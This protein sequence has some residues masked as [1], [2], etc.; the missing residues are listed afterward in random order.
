MDGI[1]NRRVKKSLTEWSCITPKPRLQL[2]GRDSNKLKFS[3]IGDI[4]YIT[5]PQSEDEIL[6]VERSNETV[7]KNNIDY[8]SY[9]AEKNP[10]FGRLLRNI[11]KTY[12]PQKIIIDDFV[13]V[14]LEEIQFKKKMIDMLPSMKSTLTTIGFSATSIFNGLTPGKI[15]IKDYMEILKK[16]KDSGRISVELVDNNIYMWKIKMKSFEN[17]E[18]SESLKIVN[19]EYGYDDIELEITFHDTMYP[20]Y[21]PFIRIVRPRI[22]KIMHQLSNLQMTKFEYWTPGRSMN[23]VIDTLYNIINKHATI[24][25]NNKVNDAQIYKNGAYLPLEESFLK[26]ATFCDDITYENEGMKLDDTQ[27]ECIYQKNS[28]KETTKDTTKKKTGGSVMND[29]GLGYVFS[30]K[31]WDHKEYI[32]LHKEKDLQLQQIIEKII[33]EI[34]NTSED[35]LHNLYSVIKSSFIMKLMNTYLHGTTILNMFEHRSIYMALFKLLQQFAN[36]NAIFLFD[37]KIIN[38]LIELDEDVNDY[39]KLSESEKEETD[40]DTK[41]TNAIRV[42]NE[43]VIPLYEKHTENMKKYEQSKKEKI[44]EL[45]KIDPNNIYVKEMKS[46]CC[47]MV[48]LTGKKQF[49]YKVKGTLNRK[50]I[51]RLGTEIA[52]FKKC[53]PIH[54]SSS[55]FVRVDENDIR[56]MRVAITGPEDTAYDS[57]IFVFDLYI[58]D[59]YPKTPP[60]MNIVNQ[61]RFRFNPNLYADGKVCLSLLGTWGTNQWDVTST[62]QQLFVSIQGQIMVDTPMYNEPSYEKHYG[63]SSGDDMNKK[64][65]NHVRYYNMKYTMCEMLKSQENYPEFSS[66]V[67]KHFT[68]KRDHILKTCKQWVDESFDSNGTIQHNSSVTIEMYKTQYK[69]LEELL[70]KLATENEQKEMIDNVDKKLTEIEKRL[71]KIEDEI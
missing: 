24:D 42:L 5:Y 15:L 59:T 66:V 23:I 32:K 10:T 1:T 41:L 70:N 36:E 6:F 26:L 47:D 58:V 30:G 11:E 51:R 34:D 2:I 35:D 62:L 65:N 19:K 37:D 16:Y 49:K 54:S 57:G 20:T 50:A 39:M 12:H 4:L 68:L 33:L 7:A 27:Y 29:K 53:L 61:G 43:M 44:E 17:K 64:Y 63:T 13:N 22:N 18:L 55:V 67:K 71:A 60:Q 38:I 9:I 25:T 3:I 28:K 69:E 21:P 14:N 52:S 8:N 56:R 46:E 45:M 48:G 40:D 31:E